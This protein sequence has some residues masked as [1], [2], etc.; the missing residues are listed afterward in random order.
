MNENMKGTVVIRR[1]SDDYIEHKGSKGMKWGYNKGKRN[2]KRT[3]EED[4]E[5]GVDT[6]FDINNKKISALDEKYIK[7]GKKYL[8]GA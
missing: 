1:S 3:A 2:G 8:V 5:A 6:P 7:I 4:I